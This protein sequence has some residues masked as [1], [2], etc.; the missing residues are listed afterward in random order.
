MHIT[1]NG[2]TT[3]TTVSTIQSLLEEQNLP[4]AGVAIAVNHTI[5]PQE[6]WA[7]TLVQEGDIIDVVHAIVGG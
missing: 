1:L 5:L 2:E 4:K 3:T 6:E 7:T